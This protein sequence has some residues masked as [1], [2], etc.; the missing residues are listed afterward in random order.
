MLSICSK[1]RVVLGDQQ[2]TI[3][4]REESVPD[5]PSGVSLRV[6][7]RNESLAVSPCSLAYVRTNSGPII[8]IAIHIRRRKITEKLDPPS[9]ATFGHSTM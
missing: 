7:G 1:R 3:H 5:G 4:V 9:E 6:E 2:E 8:P